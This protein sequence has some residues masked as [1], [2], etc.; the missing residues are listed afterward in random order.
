MSHNTSIQNGLV[1]T[2]PLLPWLLPI[3]ILIIWQIS[4]QAGWLSTRILPAPSAVF[5]AGWKL[6]L[7]GEIFHHIKVSFVRAATGF[8]IGGGAGF[9]LGLLNGLSRKAETLFDTTLQMIRNIPSLAIIPLVILW[10]GVDE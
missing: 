10:F 8:A 9:L 3:V 4:A 6:T 5:L 1:F 7:S 2:N